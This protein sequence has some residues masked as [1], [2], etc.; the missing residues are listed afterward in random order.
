MAQALCWLDGEILPAD[1]ARVP[2]LDH[3]LLYGDG[4]F[5]GI[6]FYGGHPFLLKEHLTRLRRSARAIA[7]DLHWDDTE[8]GGFIDQLIAAFTRPEGYIRLI[9]TRG[10]GPLGIDPSHCKAPRLIIIADAL[11]MIPARQRA[12]GARLIIAATRRLAP[13]GLDPRIKS[14]NYLNAILARLEATH[15]GADEAV[16]LNRDG[17][18]AEGTADN[19]FIVRDGVLLTPPSHDGALAGITRQLIL[20]LAREHAIKV[21]PSTLGPYDLYTADECFLS[22]TGAELIPVREIDG[23]PLPHCPGPIY[24]RCAEAFQAAIQRHCKGEAK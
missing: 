23:R 13:D 11:E 2:V 18:V 21:E 8:L 12:A 10:E 24:Q 4:I 6:R 16:L 17:N 19:I 5:E 20:D 3:G 1:Q 7:L 14:L 9:V 22:G 15:A